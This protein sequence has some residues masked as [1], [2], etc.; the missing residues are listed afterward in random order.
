MYITSLSAGM[1]LVGS[2]ATE[3]TK[4]IRNPTEQTFPGNRAQIV[5]FTETGFI[6]I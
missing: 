6:Y 5:L 4:T 3:N 1:G 2:R